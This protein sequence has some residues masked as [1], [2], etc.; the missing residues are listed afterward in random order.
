MLINHQHFSLRRVRSVKI[1]K[2]SEHIF[3]TFYNR[4]CSNARISGRVPLTRSYLGLSFK[5]PG[6]TETLLLV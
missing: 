3:T 5:R 1:S 4:N 6:E 2:N